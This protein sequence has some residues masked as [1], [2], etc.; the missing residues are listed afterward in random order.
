MQQ[1]FAVALM[2]SV[3]MFCGAWLQS[4]FS[5]SFWTLGIMVGWGLVVVGTTAVICRKEKD[6]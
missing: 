3:W 5:I 6:G 4:N 2:V 1:G